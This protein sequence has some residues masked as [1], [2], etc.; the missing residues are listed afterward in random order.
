MLS[1]G[2]STTHAHSD[3]PVP[4]S[5][6]LTVGAARSE[7]LVPSLFSIL[8]I[9]VQAVFPADGASKWD[10]GGIHSM[11]PTNQT[12]IIDDCTV[13]QTGMRCGETMEA[14]HKLPSGVWPCF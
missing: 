6:A 2:R 1:A 4:M 13:P 9:V 14:E 7:P 12:L 3:M 11:L 10:C 8:C 5:F